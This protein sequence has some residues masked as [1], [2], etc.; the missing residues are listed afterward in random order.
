[1]SQVVASCYKVISGLHEMYSVNYVLATGRPGPV[2]NCSVDSHTAAGFRVACEA[3]PPRG[4][5]TRYTLLV[6][7]Q[8]S[9]IWL[10]FLMLSGHLSAICLHDH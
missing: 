2:R 4:T 7:T 5:N 9:P 1:M 8:V 10:R 3:G 6:Y